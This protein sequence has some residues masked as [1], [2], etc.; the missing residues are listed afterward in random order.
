MSVLPVEQT[1]EL[2][3]NGESFPRVDSNQRYWEYDAASRAV[4][5]SPVVIDEYENEIVV[6]YDRDC[7]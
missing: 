2:A 1:L 5:I 6:R 7:E 4:L 3:I